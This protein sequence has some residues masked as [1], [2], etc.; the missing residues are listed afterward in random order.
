[1][2]RLS[3]LLA[4]IVFISLV[5]PP[6]SAMTM[7]SFKTEDVIKV[8]PGD[9]YYGYIT[10]ENPS[11]FDFKLVSFRSYR[12]TDSEG[13]DV[14][15]FNFTLKD[16]NYGGWLSHESRKV[17][18]NI[19]CEEGVKPGVYT[20]YLRFLGTTERGELQ[21]INLQTRIYVV[22]S[23]IEFNYAQAYVKERPSSP[24]V[25]RG[26]TIIVLAHLKNI[27]HRSVQVH[28]KIT[29]LRK[30][31]VYFHRE[32]GR[33]LGP[34]DNV[35]TTE[36]PVDVKWP[37]G[38]YLLKYTV[39]YDN[40][41]H[42]YAKEFPVRLGVKI[43]SVSIKTSEVESG[44]ENLVYV[45]VTSE[46]DGKVEF[47][48]KSTV[49]D[50]L[51]GAYDKVAVVSPGTKVFTLPVP[52]NVTG[53]VTV[54]LSATFLGVSLGNFLLHYTVTAPPRFINVTYQRVGEDE[55][56]FEVSVFNPNP[57]DVNG[58]VLY[59]ISSGGEVL[60]K[61]SVSASFKPGENT[62]RLRVKLPLEQNIDYEFVLVAM[63]K[64]EKSSGSLYLPKPTPTTTST[65]TTTSTTPTTSPSNTTGT[66]PGGTSN[67]TSFIV[68]LTAVFLILIG[69]YFLTREEPKKKR[70]QRPKPK[71]RSPLGRFKRPKPPKFSERGELPK[72]K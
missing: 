41:T 12:I 15:F 14:S 49:E 35:L 50:Q 62:L 57:W 43:V 52:T 72:K 8:L 29:V 5:P 16:R 65:S 33:L 1:M 34:G 9:Y 26:E 38:S 13:N 48:V 56:E 42:T 21:I 46:R 64:S 32:G 67:L 71:R 61:D 7:V 11:T 10:V 31:K 70:R 44:S 6:T 68:I 60:Y 4:L 53:N 51:V 58:S 30:G 59:R 45:T 2:K 69:A 19:S 18:Y 39:S 20:L 40:E 66:Q 55:V 47:H 28:E 37:D 24:Y 63:G 17:Y 36:I 54:N 27:G 3:I 23:P 25:L 22:E